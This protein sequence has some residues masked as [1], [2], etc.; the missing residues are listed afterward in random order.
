MQK[1][2]S[3]ERLIKF[4]CVYERERERERERKSQREVLRKFEYEWEKDWESMRERAW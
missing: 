3:N 2:I 1:E 4:F